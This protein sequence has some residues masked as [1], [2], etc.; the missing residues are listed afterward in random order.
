MQILVIHGPNLNLLGTRQPEL[1]GSTVL[2]D[3]NTQVCALAEKLSC[4]CTF[5]QSNHEG[6]LVDRI[7]M[8][9][10]KDGIFVDGIIIN[11]AA[12]THTSVALRD[13]LLA[14]DCPFVEVHL[15]NT[16]SRESFRRQS[17]L[18]DIA[19][20]TV[21]GFGKDSYLLGL[22]GLISYLKSKT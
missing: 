12:L 5:F 13:A 9:N 8:V 1:Y 14:V 19:I 6:E 21:Q 2:E 16:K 10:A 11:A 7:Q 20:G 4:H 18:E 3:I 22:Q 15:T 17:F